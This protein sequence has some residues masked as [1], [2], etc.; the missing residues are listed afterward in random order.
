MVWNRT[1]KPDP[2]VPPMKGTP[3]A[4]PKPVKRIPPPEKK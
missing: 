4:D 2:R 1:P 3:P